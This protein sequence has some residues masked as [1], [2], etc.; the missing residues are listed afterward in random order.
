[1]QCLE[2]LQKLLIYLLIILSWFNN[3]SIVALHC[4][5]FLLAFY[6]VALK[7]YRQFQFVVYTEGKFL[8]L[9][10]NFEEHFSIFPSAHFHS[11]RLL[12]SWESWEKNW[13]TSG[14]FIIIQRTITFWIFYTFITFMLLWMSR[15]LRNLR[16]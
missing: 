3:K 7:I 10:K 8:A 13:I 16:Y 15:K 6:Y 2:E 12:S 1:M 9:K 11:L 14:S 4:I 5:S